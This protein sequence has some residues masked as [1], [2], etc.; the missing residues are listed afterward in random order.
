[1]TRFIVSRFL[2]IWPVLIIVLLASFMLTRLIPGDPVTALLGQFPVPDAYRQ[3]VAHTFGVD[4]PTP[5]Q[6]WLYVTNLLKGNLGFS[7]A[8]RE[9]VLSLVLGRAMNSLLLMVPVLVISSILGVALGVLAAS[10]KARAFDVAVTTVTLAGYSIPI[11]WLGQMLILLFAVRLHWLPVQGMLAIRGLEP[12]WPTV[13]NFIQHWLMPGFTATLFYLAVV[14]RVA[15]SSLREALGQDFITT[16]RSKGLS[17]REVLWKHALPNSLIPVVTVIGYNFGYAITGTI[18]VEAV[19]GWPG[20]GG[21]F[22]SSIASRD[23]PVLQAIFLLTSVAVVLANLITD[24][25]Y[26]VVD[27]R[28]RYE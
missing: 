9:P 10:T 24:F 14:A 25:L 2:A 7:F 12:G 20:L 27:P 18:I 26:G 17:E 5:V 23:Y 28:V 21:L 8:N 4:Q 3:E 11:F 6:L 22:V 16:A 1:M 19:F 15:R 13:W